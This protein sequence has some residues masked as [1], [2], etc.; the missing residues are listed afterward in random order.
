M[1]ARPRGQHCASALP[2]ATLNSG[3]ASPLLRPATPGALPGAPRTLSGCRSPS[4]RRNGAGPAWRNRRPPPPRGRRA[5]SAPRGGARL[6]GRV[7][8]RGA[9]PEGKRGGGR[10]VSE[11]LAGKCRLVLPKTII[12]GGNL[13]VGLLPGVWCRK[14]RPSGTFRGRRSLA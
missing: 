7:S 12:F 10:A 6:R 8:W 9:G 3:P 13:G 2:P 1:R 14:Q 4:G 5:V 11:V